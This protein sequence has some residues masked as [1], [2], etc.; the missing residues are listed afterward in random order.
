MSYRRVPCVLK[1][2]LIGVHLLIFQE[3]T[4][5]QYSLARIPDFRPVDG[6]QLEACVQFDNTLYD[7]MQ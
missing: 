3:P 4:Q 5:S 6:V 1:V 7:S 2:L